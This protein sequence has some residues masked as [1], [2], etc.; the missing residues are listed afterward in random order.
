MNRAE[1]LTQISQRNPAVRRR[2]LDV[3]NTI[4]DNML[5]EINTVLGRQPGTPDR[6]LKFKPATTGF[7]KM[8]LA[9]TFLGFYNAISGDGPV[10]FS[11][12]GTVVEIKGYEGKII[13]AL[14]STSINYN[15][16]V[17]QAMVGLLKRWCSLLISGADLKHMTVDVVA[18]NVQ[19]HQGEVL[20]AMR[21]VMRDNGFNFKKSKK[22]SADIVIPAED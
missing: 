6:V 14:L 16:A 15:P 19:R 5:L 22:D 10:T 8:S 4:T 11:I 18:N 9:D 2:V 1:L 3:E 21:R 13:Q 7:K 17:T 20:N 12:M